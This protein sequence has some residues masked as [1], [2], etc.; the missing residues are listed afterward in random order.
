MWSVFALDLQLLW[1]AFR[2]AMFRVEGPSADPDS[3]TLTQNNVNKCLYHTR[4]GKISP[5]GVCCSQLNC[6]WH[7]VLLLIGVLGFVVGG[8]VVIVVGV[9]LFYPVPMSCLRIYINSMYALISTERTNTESGFIGRDLSKSQS[10]WQV[11]SNMGA[12]C[13]ET[14][15]SIMGLCAA[16]V[17]LIGDLPKLCKHWTLLL[18]RKWERKLETKVT[19]ENEHRES[20]CI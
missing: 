11:C 3:T 2:E 18:F 20:N 8:V 19:R 6:G 17:E 10:T 15:L 4:W 7:S 1:V 9:V 5:N 14:F 16:E 13:P 12:Y